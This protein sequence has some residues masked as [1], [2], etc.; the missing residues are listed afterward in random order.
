MFELGVH[1]YKSMDEFKPSEHLT[2]NV[3]PLLIF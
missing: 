1:D 2:A 3:K